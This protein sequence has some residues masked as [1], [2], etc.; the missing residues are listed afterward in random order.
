MTLLD[1][2]IRSM[3]ELRN[4]RYLQ[5]FIEARERRIQLA[6]QGKST[7]II[8]L[9][10]HYATYQAIFRKGWNSVTE[11]DIRTAPSVEGLCQ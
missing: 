6:Q 1:I 9:Y 10:S 2:L 7:N 5:V 8:P 11:F 4:R 3:P